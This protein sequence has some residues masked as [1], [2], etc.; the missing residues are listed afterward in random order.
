VLHV[1]EV[2]REGGETRKVEAFRRSIGQ[3]SSQSN[4]C[5]LFLVHISGRL[6]CPWKYTR[7]G[8]NVRE[9]LRW[10]SWVSFGIGSFRR[11]RPLGT[12]KAGLAGFFWHQMD[13]RKTL[14]D[15]IGEHGWHH[16]L[17]SPVVADSLADGAKGAFN[18]RS[19]DSIVI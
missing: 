4:I 17:P 13:V 10:F 11:A 3:P 16:K 12:E 7:I 19:S 15:A 6:F 2:Q 18:P 8:R 14:D 5:D 1:H 9:D